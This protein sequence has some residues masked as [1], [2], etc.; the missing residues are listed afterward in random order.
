MVAMPISADVRRSVQSV[1]PNSRK[2]P[3][4]MYM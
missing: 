2:T 4:M 3:A 1:E